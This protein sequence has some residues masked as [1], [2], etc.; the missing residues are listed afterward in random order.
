[1]KRLIWP[2]IAIITI[3]GL[4]LAIIEPFAGNSPKNFAYPV[5]NWNIVYGGGEFG[6][7]RAEKV[8]HLGVDT[9]QKA[10][11]NVYAAQTGTVKHIGIHSRF[12][13]VILIEHK[14]KSGE[15]VVS[16]YGHL[17]SSDVAVR[18]GQLVSKRQLIGRIGASGAENG[19]WSEHLHFAVRRGAYQDVAKKWVY[20]GMG[21]KT[22]LQNWYDPD[23]FFSGSVGKKIDPANEGKIL[24][25]PGLGGRTRVK[26]FGSAGNQIENS[27]I[28]A[29]AYD[30]YGGGDVAFG[31]VAG[32]KEKEIVVGA[33]KDSAPYIKIYDK[34]TK[35]L[36]REFLAFAEGF[37]GGVRVA[38]GDINGD[39]KDEIIAGAGPGGGAHVRVFDRNG[40]VIYP[41]LFPFG[42]SLRTGVDVAAGDTD[43]NGKDEIIVSQGPGGKPEVKVYQGNGKLTKINFFAYD[44]RFKGGVKVAGGDVDGDGKDEIITGAGPG[45][46]PHV[47]VFEADGKP[48]PAWFFAFH[49]DF[50]GGIDVASAA[51]DSDKKDEIIVSQASQGQAW[52]K[53]YQ[54]NERKTILAEFLAYYDGFEGGTSVAGLK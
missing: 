16:L 24:T 36:I 27:D 9:A 45:G 49:K 52:V 13:T 17:R 12:G 26:L 35:N 54:Y 7:K 42:K 51:I 31:D 47:R 6:V 3:L 25:V 28:Y 11:T 4:I 14:L 1:M 10:G 44:K 39:G 41:K 53:I 29:S 20:W 19:F 38:T 2:K 23:M 15:K 18:E 22:E 30:F 21:D 32:N 48:K 8:Y 37:R 50:R 5:N 46:G 43:G 40:K 33:G 34:N